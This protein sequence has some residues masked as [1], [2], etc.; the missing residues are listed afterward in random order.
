MVFGGQW[1]YSFFLLFISSFLFTYQRKHWIEILIPVSA[2]SSDVM[3]L[4][5]PHSSWLHKVVDSLFRITSD[6]DARWTSRNILRHAWTYGSSFS[7]TSFLLMYNFCDIHG[8][9]AKQATNTLQGTKKIIFSANFWQIY[10]IPWTPGEP[11][12]KLH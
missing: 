7:L 1:N 11:T 5:Y 8:N 10:K 12:I 9:G 4:A 3:W 2:W 6:P